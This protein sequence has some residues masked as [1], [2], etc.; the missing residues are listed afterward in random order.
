MKVFILCF[1]VCCFLGSAS[2]LHAQTGSLHGTIRDAE[3]GESMVGASV[4]VEGQ[5]RGCATDIDGKYLI[6]GLTP[7]KV[8]LRISY[9]GYAEML[10]QEIEI[11]GG[12]RKRID[13]SLSQEVLATDEVVISADRVLETESAMLAA[14]KISS[15]IGDGF[16]SEQVSIT[17]ASTTSDALKRVT[18]VTIVDNK[19]VYVRGVTDRYNSTLLD[20]VTV[21]STDTDVDKKSFAFD[22]VPAKLVKNTIVTKSASPDLPADFSGG[23]VRINMVDFPDNR[24]FKVNLSTSTQNIATGKDILISQGSNTDWLGMDDGLRNAPEEGLDRHELGKALPNTWAQRRRSGPL[25]LG[26]SLSYGD[27]YE[28]G[29]DQ[30]G[31]IA[32]ATYNTGYSRTEIDTRYALAPTVILREGSGV[33]DKYSAAWGLVVNTGYKFAGNHKLRLR[34]SFNQTGEDKVSSQ[35]LDDG[36]IFE[37]VHVSEWDERS[38]YVSQLSGDHVLPGLGNAKVSWRAGYTQSIAREPDRKTYIYNR[39]SDEPEWPLAHSFA[40]RSWAKLDEYSRTAGIDITVPLGQQ[41]KVKVGGVFEKRERY[42]DIE[43]YQTELD[44][45]SRN[46]YLRLLPIDSIFVPENYGPDYFEMKILSAPSDKYRGEHRLG[47]AYAMVDL[48]FSIMEE[49]FRIAGGVRME[50]SEQLV[51]TTDPTS[52]NLPFVSRVATV[53]YLPSMN[54]TYQLNDITNLR[55]AYG[56][57]VNRPEFR[58]LA[59]FYFYD[60]SLYQGAY[61]NPNLRRAYVRNYDIRFELFP[62]MGEVIAVSWFHKSLTDAIEVKTIPSSNPER[63]WFNSPKGTNAGW[64]FEVRKDFGFLGSWYRN[65][66]VAGN[67]TIV[68]SEI[69]YEDGAIVDGETGEVIP[70]FSTRDMQGQSPYVINLSLLVNVP[71]SG[72]RMTLLF[73]QFGD[74]MHAVGDLREKDIMELSHPTVDLTF[75]QEMPFDGVQLKFSWLNALDERK[76]FELRNGGS[77]RQLYTGSKFSLSMSYS[78]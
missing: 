24:L 56:H 13:V 8:T 50:D 40:D 38:V 68:E 27:R 19:F 55:L 69:E 2:F 36:D 35:T 64:E 47:A 70:V 78:F 21:T 72:T 45:L 28:V 17:P 48:P 12:E 52:L 11:E 33:I 43:F 75:I 62:G 57:S 46:F 54:F 20:G 32:A 3:S 74:R 26:L 65:I 39:P 73:H 41:G 25:G 4:L 18:G 31:F 63:T 59:S 61:G 51:H 5:S 66:M 76:V 44:L 16:S 23:L 22:M 49:K 42:Y 58:E 60:Y 15:T 6:S 71:E 14:R 29:D 10:V 34:N 9:I 77:Y 7:G 37:D 67:Y 53:D 30:L 1:T